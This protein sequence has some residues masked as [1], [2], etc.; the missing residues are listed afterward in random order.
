MIVVAGACL[1]PAAAAPLAFLGGATGAAAGVA[2][3]GI[4]MG[5]QEATVRAAVADMTPPERRAGAYG[6]FD[7]TFGLAWFAGSA[8]MGVLYGRAPLELVGFSVVTQLVAVVLLGVA[9]RM[10]HANRKK[11]GR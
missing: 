1:L 3:W 9:A 2:L 6:L 8:L 10:Q 5:V 11:I 4:G 7:A